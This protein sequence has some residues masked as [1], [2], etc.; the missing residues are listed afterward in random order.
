MRRAIASFIDAN[1]VPGWLFQD[2]KTIIRV[3]GQITYVLTGENW[4]CQS[5][6]SEFDR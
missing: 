4:R 3:I 5:K 1:P 6:L 2:L